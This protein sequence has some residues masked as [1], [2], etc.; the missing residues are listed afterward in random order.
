MP[1]CGRNGSVPGD[2]YSGPGSAL[3][4]LGRHNAASPE[5]TTSI[6]KKLKDDVVI[7]A[8]VDPKNGDK[9]PRGI[10][11][12]SSSY[13]ELKKGQVL[14]CNFENKAG[15]AGKGTTVEVLDPKPGS[16]PATF[17]QNAKIEGCSDVSISPAN[18]D[19]YVTGFTSG[20]VVQFG[21]TGKLG[22]T[23]GKPLVKPFS[24]V[25][26]ACVGNASQCGYSADD[27][28]VSDAKTGDI[29][30]FSVNEYGNPV[31]TEVISGFA[32]NKKSGWSALGP[33]GLSFISPKKGTLFVADGPDNSIV[34]VNHVTSL[35]EPSEIIVQKG[36]KTFK[37]KYPKMS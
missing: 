5:E 7:S 3:R 26:G 15:N 19:V 25:D 16:K 8:T 22:S 37:C 12:V 28:F 2:A 11:V 29:V 34:S 17:A 21:P 1:A 27:V 35:L 14:V 33:S 13:G 30:S 18:D 9:G 32:V 36:G 20:L 31:P 24:L 10:A 23:L 4:L 6:L